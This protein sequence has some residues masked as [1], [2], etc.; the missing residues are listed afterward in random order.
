MQSKE[1]SSIQKTETTDTKTDTVGEQC[2]APNLQ[3]TSLHRTY[4]KFELPIKRI[5]L[6][7]IRP[8]MAIYQSSIIVLANTLY[9]KIQT[10]PKFI[11]H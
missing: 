10:I 5:E 7:K 4:W 11:T 3:W 1:Y 6:I 8:F 9:C 2:N